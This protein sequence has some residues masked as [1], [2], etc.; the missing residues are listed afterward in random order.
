MR[1]TDTPVSD[2]DF[3]RLSFLTLASLESCFP[4][5]PRARSTRRALRISYAG[6]YSEPLYEYLRGTYCLLTLTSLM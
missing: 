5:N 6:Y 1:P 2:N 3:K 4:R